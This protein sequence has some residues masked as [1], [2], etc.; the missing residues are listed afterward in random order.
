MWPIVIL[1][2][3]A[4]ILYYRDYLFTPAF[5]LPFDTV[6]KEKIHAKGHVMPSQRSSEND[7]SLYSYIFGHREAVDTV[8]VKSER[9]EVHDHKNKTSKT[10]DKYISVKTQKNRLMNARKAYWRQDL[11]QAEKAYLALTNSMETPN[12]YGELGNIY[13]MQSRWQD[14]SKAYYYAAIKLKLINRIDQAY[15]LLQ[16]IRTLDM[17]TADKLQTE[18]M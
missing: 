5:N 14:A 15:Y 16:V 18:L 10:A 9:P 12:V 4:T 1:A 17:S 2:V 3:I 11:K 6:F 13:Y 8:D 7:K